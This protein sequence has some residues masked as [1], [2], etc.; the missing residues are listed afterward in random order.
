MQQ[1]ITDVFA[2]LRRRRQGVENSVE[3][4]ERRREEANQDSQRELAELRVS[5]CEAFKNQRWS[6]VVALEHHQADDN[7]DWPIGPDLADE[8]DF[9]FANEDEELPEWRPHWDIAVG[10][11][12]D[13]DLKLASSKLSD[14]RLRELA[15]QA[16]Q[17][18]L[19]I[20][21]RA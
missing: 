4:A 10:A 17:F 19:T 18:R 16:V 8:F 20:N 21:K 2:N 14:A 3:Q 7:R 15:E 9:F 5:T 12:G 13:S 1:L 6:R 11:R